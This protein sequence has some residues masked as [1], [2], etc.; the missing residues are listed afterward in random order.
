MP[1]HIYGIRHHGAGSAKHLVAELERLCPD[2]I[3][4][5][6]PSDVSSLL[7]ATADPNMIPPVALL[8][9]QVDDQ[10]NAAYYPFAEFSPE[11]QAIRYAHRTSVP[12]RFCDLP[13]MYS[14]GMRAQLLADKS[15]DEPLDIPLDIPP[16]Q[17]DLLMFDDEPTLSPGDHLALIAGFR[18]EEAWWESMVEHRQNSEG[19]FE[20]IEQAFAAL[21]EEFPEATRSKNLVREAWMRKQIRLAEREGY[22]RIAVVCGAWHA[23]ALRA[24][25]SAKE[26]N[27][28]LKGLPK[29][30]VDYT[31]IP[32]TYDRL[33]IQSGYGAGITAPGWYDYR[34]NNPDDNGILWVSRVSD[35]L[36]Q[37]GQ[38]ISVA[39][40]IEVLRLART[41]AS[42]RGRATPNLEDYNE[43]IVA[44]IG[45]GDDTILNLIH[46]EMIVSNRL[47]SVP[48]SVPKVPLLVDI[49]KAQ[50]R[51]RLH[52]NEEE[53]TLILD[54][55][56]PNDQKRSVLLHRL[57]LIGIHWGRER[58]VSGKGTFKEVWT[59]VYDP[60]YIVQIIERAVWGNTLSEACRAY[61]SHKISSIE[62]LTDLTVLLR[63]ALPANLPLFVAEMIR[64]IRVLSATISD[65]VQMLKA[66]PKIIHVMMYGTVRSIDYGMLKPVAEML[67]NRIVAGG[68]M[69]MMGIDYTT[70]LSIQK[71][72][73]SVDFSMRLL[74]DDA[75]LSVW[76][77]FLRSLSTTQGVHPLLSGCA[78]RLLR[79]AEQID[80]QEQVRLLSVHTS[81]AI[82]VLHTAYWLE[83]FLRGSALVL[84]VDDALLELIDG[85]I[86]SLDDDVFI[87]LLPVIR[88]IFGEYTATERRKI[89]E[90]ASLIDVRTAENKE[91]LG[92]PEVDEREAVKALPL[93]RQLLGLD[94]EN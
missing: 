28:L 56:K 2:I 85:W 39:H 47:G 34:W 23:P 7:E 78:T 25:K 35:L 49:E 76:V 38:D 58:S 93:L 65:V 41:V 81:T 94:I 29:V 62:S 77:G 89:G 63:E 83:G 73:S 8:A 92:V 55:R 26:D 18:D 27:A 19:I 50:K 84:L 79:E 60:V 75:L 88:R 16:D 37:A 14:L 71:S 74:Q 17:K 54:L 80:N 86:A 33:S 31:W 57:A 46:R 13:L 67:L 70:A 72:L 22:D 42:L 24:K 11:W 5:E 53:K 48:D 9:Y 10:S 51:L 43:A 82:P 66:L 45:H 61:L 64:R 91:V 69:A 68:L 20:A 15:L 32:W 44:V 21:R 6:G 90:R 1:V 30:K 87:E 12:V 59:L 3:L 4:I 52:F 40:T 36:R